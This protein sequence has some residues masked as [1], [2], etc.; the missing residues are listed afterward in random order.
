M[1]LSCQSTVDTRQAAGAFYQSL[2]K[3]AMGLPHGQHPVFGLAQICEG[4]KADAGQYVPEWES[5][6]VEVARSGEPGWTW[7]K[8]TLTFTDIPVLPKPVTANTSTCGA[9]NPTVGGR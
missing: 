1:W 8:Y 4:M 3:D 6:H 5:Q 7:G 2:A 9:G